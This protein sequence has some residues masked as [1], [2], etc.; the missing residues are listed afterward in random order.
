MRHSGIAAWTLAAALVAPGCGVAASAQ[1]ARA[2]QA[3]PD[4]AMLRLQRRHGAIQMVVGGK[5][6][7]VRGGELGRASAADLAADAFYAYAALNSMGFDVYAPEFLPAQQEK[8]LAD[9]YEVIGQLTPLILTNQGTG[10]MAGIRTPVSFDGTV[11]LAPQQLTLG[12]YTFDVHF[13]EP[14]PISTGAKTVAPMPGAHGG[15]IIQTGDDEFLVAG[16]GMIVTF[17]T[18]GEGIAGIDSIWEGRFVNGTWVA[19][20]NLNGDDDNQG[21]YLRVP[22]GEFTIRHVRLY[23][24]H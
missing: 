12:D 13:K 7:L 8:A 16:T 11:D 6:F 14:A 10:K 9:A 18:R 24:Y 22:S 19:G 3:A 21:R 5:P 4:Q 23:T 15:F 1:S 2:V 17:G 20:R